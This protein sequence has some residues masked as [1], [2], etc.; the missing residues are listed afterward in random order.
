METDC[1]GI[2]VYSNKGEKEAD[3]DKDKEIRQLIL[4]CKEVVPKLTRSSRKEVMNK[5][6][7]A[8]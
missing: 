3:K 4:K 7:D 5:K 1:N 6:T 2:N 8:E